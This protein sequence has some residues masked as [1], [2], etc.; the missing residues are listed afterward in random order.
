MI[1]TLDCHPPKE[2]SPNARVHWSKR[3]RVAHDFR[4]MVRFE[5]EVQMTNEWKAPHK[6]SVSLTIVCA[7]ARIRDADN[8]LCRFKP[9]MDGLVDAD[10]LKADDVNH[11]TVT[12]VAFVVN[13][14]AAPRTIIEIKAVR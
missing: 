14:K 9:G 5:A 10:V 11:L 6:A 2:C 3:A 1:I 8:W 4:S 12:K 13:N 7:E